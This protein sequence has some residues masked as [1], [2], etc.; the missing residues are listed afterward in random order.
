MVP[1][2]LR[3]LLPPPV[4]IYSVPGLARVTV[5]VAPAVLA[6][7]VFQFERLQEVTGILVIPANGTPEALA[8]L[9][10]EIQDEHNEP[11]FTDLQGLTTTTR[12]PFAQPCEALFGRALLPFPLKRLVG[13]GDR[14]TF[15]FRNVTGVAI[16]VAGVA[17][18]HRS[19]DQS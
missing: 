6:P 2:T 14:W 9:S 16:L 3:K 5:P 4:R 7:V 15:Q 18:Y 12:L 10:I 1:E 17:L 13:P 8:G 11:L 19:P